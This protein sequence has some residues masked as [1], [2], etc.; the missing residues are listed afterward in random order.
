MS[1]IG[2]PQVGDTPAFVLEA[3]ITAVDYGSVM[4]LSGI[5][6]VA[7]TDGSTRGPVV[8]VA[9]DEWPPVADTA[10]IAFIA[11]TDLVK[12]VGYKTYGGATEG[13]KIPIEMEEVIWVLVD[14]PAGGSDITIA[15]GDDLVPCLQSGS[16]GC[17][18]IAAAHA[19]A[20][21]NA[22]EINAALDEERRVFARALSNIHT[23]HRTGSNRPALG[24]NNAN[25]LSADTPRVIGWVLAKMLL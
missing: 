17:E 8:G 25:L 9:K 14:I 23:S 13:R 19:M 15:P 5:M 2:T 16:F 4:Y 7:P 11:E 6:E 12:D 24:V 22:A 3:A 18:T 20:T 21:P 10:G 1:T